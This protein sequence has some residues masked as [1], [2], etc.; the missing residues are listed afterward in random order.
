MCVYV[1]K[2]VRVYMHVCMH[3]G[4]ITPTH[5]GTLLPL[6]HTP[7]KTRTWEKEMSTYQRLPTLYPSH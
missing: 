2:C 1:Y 5:I 4:D 6:N 7:A 3:T